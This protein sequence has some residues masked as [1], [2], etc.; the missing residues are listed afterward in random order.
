MK[1]GYPL[2]EGSVRPY[3]LWDA[4]N[5]QA[6]RYRY[7]SDHK[8]AHMGALIEARWA[9]VGTTIEVYNANT[10]KLLGQYTRRLHNI[11][12]TGE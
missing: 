6:I 7:F 3:H 5:R 9:K 4:N 1:N 10:G 11:Q 8:R 12:F 2:S